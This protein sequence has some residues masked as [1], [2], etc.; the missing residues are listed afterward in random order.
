MERR[1]E[2]ACEPELPPGS[3]SR[4]EKVE[5]MDIVPYV[6]PVVLPGPN[7]AVETILRTEPMSTGDSATLSSA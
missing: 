7:R 6:M 2:A 4:D 5:E 3:V 1:D